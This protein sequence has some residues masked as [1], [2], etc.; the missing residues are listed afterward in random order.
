[1]SAASVERRPLVLVAGACLGGWAWREV[2]SALRS[3]GHDVYPATLTG[4]GERVHLAAPGVDLETHVTD[5]VNLLDYEAL[6]DAVLV[7]HSYAGTVVTAAAD[8]RPQRLNAVVYLDTSPLPNGTAIA[9]VQSPEQLERQRRAVREHGEGWRWPVPDR[10]TLTTGAFGSTSGLS[11][12]HLQL[13][14][15]RATP[16][17]YATMTSPV[18]LAHDRPPGVRRAAIFCTAGGVDTTRVR[19]LAARHDPRAAIFADG[20]WELH[21]LPTGHWAMLSLPGPLAELLHRIV[22][23]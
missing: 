2:A 10:D 22:E 21:D 23:R 4:L 14:A 19:E 7:G 6:A 1:M 11:D 18:R 17:P 5:V 16:Q 8:R 15:Q 9:D 3:Q 13:I 12:E 20:D